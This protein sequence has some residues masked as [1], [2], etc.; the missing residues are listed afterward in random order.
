LIGTVVRTASLFS[1][2]LQLFFFFSFLFQLFLTFFVLKIRF[3]QVIAL[4]GK[5]TVEGH[6]TSQIVRRRASAAKRSQQK[7][8]DKAHEE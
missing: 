3:G 7:N 8:R 1:L 6:D 4:L 2:A 5:H